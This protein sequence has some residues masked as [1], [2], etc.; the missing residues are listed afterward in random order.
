MDNTLWFL[1]WLFIFVLIWLLPIVWAVRADHP[2]RTLI[3]V[4]KNRD[5]P[6]INSL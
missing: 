2:Q 6:P 5:T 1:M 3:I 4:L